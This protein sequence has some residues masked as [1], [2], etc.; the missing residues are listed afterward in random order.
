VPEAAQFDPE[1]RDRA[2]QRRRG[3]A[4]R[5]VPVDG[6]VLKRREHA[7]DPVSAM[8]EPVTFQT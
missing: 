6:P 5:L 8:K 3:R 1:I 7:L 2:L 4:E